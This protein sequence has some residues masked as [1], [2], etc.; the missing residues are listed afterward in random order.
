MPVPED[1]LPVLLPDEVQFKPT[2]ESPLRYV[3]E[4]LNTTCPICGGPA[5]RETDTMDTFICSSWYFLR[6]ADPQNDARS[7][8]GGEDGA[9]A[10]G[11]YVHRRAR[12]RRRCTCCTRASSS[13]RC[14][15]WGC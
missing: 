6:Y 5:T 7:L 12:A 11:G 3:P 4:F 13:R 10:A 9:V 2:G 1:Q 8:D 14:A 15:T